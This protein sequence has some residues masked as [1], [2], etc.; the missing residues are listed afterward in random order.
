MS[1]STIMV[2][3]LA[4][5]TA[6]VAGTFLWI[7]IR[8]K[9][10]DEIRVDVYH[11]FLIAEHAFKESGSG[12]MKY[13]VSQ[14]RRLLPSWLQYFITDDFLESVIE[15]WFQSVKDLLDDGKLNGSEEE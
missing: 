12:K 3:I 6:L 7:Y 4:V 15:K 2:I 5:L 10:I 9:T 14:A 13:V 8:D 1:T 11:L